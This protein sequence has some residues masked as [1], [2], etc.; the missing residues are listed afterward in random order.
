MSLPTRLPIHTPLTYSFGYYI[1]DRSAIAIIG[2]K[3]S[4]NFCLVNLNCRNYRNRKL[5]TDLIC[6]TILGLIALIIIIFMLPNRPNNG[7]FNHSFSDKN[8][9]S[10]LSIDYCLTNLSLP[11]RTLSEN[12]AVL[13]ISFPR[14]GNSYLRSV[15][16]LLT[17][18]ITGS[19][20]NDANIFTT[21]KDITPAI[22]T[23]VKY[24]IISKNI[25]IFK[26]HF[27]QQNRHFSI[28]SNRTI[29][30][31]LTLNNTILTMQTIKRIIYI[32]RNPLDS[33]ISLYHFAG[34]HYT[35]HSYSIQLAKLKQEENQFKVFIRHCI[36]DWKAHNQYFLDLSSSNQNPLNPIQYSIIRYEDFAL[37]RNA[38]LYLHSNILHQNQSNFYF[39]L[40]LI[41]LLKWINISRSDVTT[42]YN[43]SPINLQPSRLYCTETLLKLNQADTTVNNNNNIVHQLSRL[44]SRRSKLDNNEHEGFKILLSNVISNGTELFRSIITSIKSLLCELNYSVLYGL[45]HAECENYSL[46]TKNRSRIYFFT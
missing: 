27:Y 38:R 34:S 1:T 8:L 40:E 6:G 16:E 33:C 35:N 19:N 5:K 31:S 3:S 12:P 26:H 43:Y 7:L 22:N 11:T 37:R 17:G 24:K 45:K 42:S 29:D 30:F 2:M 4:V 41:R 9:F 44:Y 36:Q 15:L 13:L 14:S 21:F 25:H 32:I 10:G 18:Y 20:N 28:E 39:R 23:S 46:Y